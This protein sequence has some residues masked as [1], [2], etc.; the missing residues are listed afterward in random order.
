MQ[1]GETI[2]QKEFPVA[3]SCS[4]AV[5]AV[6]LPHIYVLTLLHCYSLCMQIGE[7]VCQKEFPVALPTI[8]VEEPTVSMTFKVREGVGVLC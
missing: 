2:C 1:I 3:D 7:T 4:V 5:V 8:Q 6:P